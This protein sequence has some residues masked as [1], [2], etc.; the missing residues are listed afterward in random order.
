MDP[1]QTVARSNTTSSLRHLY[2]SGPTGRLVQG[3]QSLIG[4]WLGS[5]HSADVAAE[6]GAFSPYGACAEHVSP[7]WASLES[8]KHGTEQPNLFAALC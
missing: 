5:R 2:G 3:Q 1:I 6:P 4:Q 8:A 7:F